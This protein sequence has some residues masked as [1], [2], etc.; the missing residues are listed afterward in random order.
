MC[1]PSKREAERQ[2]ETEME[3]VRGLTREGACLQS[4]PD[5]PSLSPWPTWWSVRT[6]PCT[7]SSPD[8]PLYLC[9]RKLGVGSEKKKE[10]TENERI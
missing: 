6:D 4:K 8:S 3:P 10:E 2:K 1:K 7:M 9:R 5:G